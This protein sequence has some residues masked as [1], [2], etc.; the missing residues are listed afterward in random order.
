MV[1]NAG[2][3]PNSVATEGETP[4]GVAAMMNPHAEITSALLN[5]GANPNHREQNG[6]TALHWPAARQQHPKVITAL[7]EA[8]TTP[9]AS[10]WTERHR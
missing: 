3:D 1:I 8:G 10:Q 4:V 2:G 6:W 7:V 9:T 5:G